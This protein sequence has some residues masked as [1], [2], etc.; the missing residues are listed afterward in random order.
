MYQL[1]Y[2]DWCSVRQE[3]QFLDSCWLVYMVTKT[4]YIVSVCTLHA[5]SLA[6]V[7]MCNR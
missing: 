3:Q 5:I 6:V 4:T 2:A 7:Y 1:V